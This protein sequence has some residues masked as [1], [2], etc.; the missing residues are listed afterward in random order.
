MGEDKV[1]LQ[2]LVQSEANRGLK[3]KFKSLKVKFVVR[4]LEPCSELVLSD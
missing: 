2:S 1:L 3:V 4:G